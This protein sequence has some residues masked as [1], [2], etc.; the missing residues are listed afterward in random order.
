MEVH[1]A[2]IWQ[3][4]LNRLWAV[5]LQPLVLSFFHSTTP[6]PPVIIVVAAAAAVLSE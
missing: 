5:A 2:A 4:R 1:I 6:K 3:I